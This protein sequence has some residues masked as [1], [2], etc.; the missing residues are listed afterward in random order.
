V[1]HSFMR[2]GLSSRH[3]AAPACGTGSSVV[4]AFSRMHTKIGVVIEGPI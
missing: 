2:D 3:I 1:E 4:F